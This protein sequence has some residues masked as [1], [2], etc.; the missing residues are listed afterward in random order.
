MD[1]DIVTALRRLPGKELEALYVAGF[2]GGA[3]E[4]LS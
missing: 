3:S 4:I 1:V 2:T